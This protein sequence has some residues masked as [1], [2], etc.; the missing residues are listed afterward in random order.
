MTKTIGIDARMFGLKHAGIGRYTSS[1]IE[2]I[3]NLDQSNRFN[4]ILFVRKNDHKSIK[5]QYW[6]KFHYIEVDFD[7]YSLKEQFLLPLT[8]YWSNCD[9][10][11]FPHFNVPLL[12]WKPFAVTIHDL[13]KHHSRGKETTTRNPAIY[14]LKFFFYQIVIR[15]AIKKAQKIFT[16]SQFVKEEISKQYQVNPQKIIVTYEGVENKLF[17]NK[18]TGRSSYGKEILA[19][20][21]EKI[22]QKYQIKKPYLLYVGSVYPHKNIN[23]LVEAVKI[24]RKTIPN[25]YLVIVCS[26]S[27][28]WQRLKKTIGLMKAENFVNLT[29]FVPD[30]EL[31]SLYQNSSAFVFPSLSEGFGLP[32]LE[33][34]ASSCPVISSNATCLPEIYGKAALFFDPLNPQDMAE[35]IIKMVTS[36]KIQKKYQALGLEKVKKYSWKKMTEKTISE[37]QKI[38]N[39][40]Q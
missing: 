2:T 31:A 21:K 15:Q 29:G 24:V 22:L 20:E 38:I 30:E 32:P 12:Y 1:L 27:V 14:Q 37:Y 34:M 16:P 11:H 28:F 17:S 23:R 39:P 10:V 3:S 26:R 9:L 33:A 36:K 13:I 8:L 5:K 7:H 35:K 6:D 40:N 4:W 18:T 25:L 19:K